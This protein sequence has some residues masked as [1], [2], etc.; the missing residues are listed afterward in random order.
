MGVETELALSNVEPHMFIRCNTTEGWIPFETCEESGHVFPIRNKNNFHYNTTNFAD[1]YEAIG[2][3]A[4]D[5]QA[6]NWWNTTI[7]WRNQ[8]GN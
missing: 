4:E 3:C 5:E 7:I 6:L 8:D 2:G 1:I